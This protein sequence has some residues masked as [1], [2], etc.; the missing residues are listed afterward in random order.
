MSSDGSALPLQQPC[1]LRAKIPV[2][3]VE[4]STPRTHRNL[5]PVAPAGVEPSDQEQPRIDPL[6]GKLVGQESASKAAYRLVLY[7]CTFS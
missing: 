2:V 3:P 5:L 1:Q 7:P 4:N 6:C